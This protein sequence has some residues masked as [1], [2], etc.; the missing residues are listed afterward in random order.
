VSPGGYS[1]RF[2]H[3]GPRRLARRH[4]ACPCRLCVGDLSG[5]VGPRS[6]KALRQWRSSVLRQ[7]SVTLVTLSVQLEA[8]AESQAGNP[9]P[10]ETAAHVPSGGQGESDYIGGFY[11]RRGRQ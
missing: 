3:L 4:L 2:Y 6:I 1:I 8:A 7:T 9:G 5:S 11:S 10:P